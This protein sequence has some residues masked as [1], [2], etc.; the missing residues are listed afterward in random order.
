MQGPVVSDFRCWMPMGGCAGRAGCLLH[1]TGRYSA[2]WVGCYRL[3][4]LIGQL[5]AAL[6]RNLKPRV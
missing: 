4:R 1:S 3:L 6:G 5:H 2:V